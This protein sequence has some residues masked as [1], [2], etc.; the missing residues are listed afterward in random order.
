MRLSVRLHRPA[1]CRASLN[2]FEPAPLPSSKIVPVHADNIAP[3]DQ[4]KQKPFVER[5][6]FCTANVGM[7]FNLKRV[8]KT[9]YLNG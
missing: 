1:R 8:F 7:R 4:T 2:V 9:H 3:D 5:L 6:H